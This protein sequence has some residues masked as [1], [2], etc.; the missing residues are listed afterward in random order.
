MDVSTMPIPIPG[1]AFFATALSLLCFLGLSAVA[2]AA[3]DADANASLSANDF[4]ALAG[5]KLEVVLKADKALN[6]SWISLGKDNQGR[7]LL[8]GQRHQALTR[9]TLGKDGKIVKTQVLMLPVSEIMGQLY[10]NDS[11]YIDGWGKAADGTELFGLFRLRDPE[12][13][14][15]FGRV[16]LLREWKHGWREHGAHAIVLGPDK[17]HLFI[18]CGNFVELPNDLA[19]TSPHKNYAD[20]QPLPREEDGNGFG[21]GKKPPGGFIARLD[22]DGRNPELYAAGQRNTY[23]IAFNPD[24]ELFGFD[25]DMEYDW[26]T[27]WY[28]PIRVYHATSGEDGG[29]REGTAK[30]PDYYPDGLPPVVNIGI[31]CPTGV[32]FGAGAKFPARYQKALFVQDW[33][34]ARLM[35]VHLK[36]KGSTY[37]STGWENL[38]APKS[39]HGNGVKKPLNLTGMVVGDDGALY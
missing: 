6:G 37:E 25:S 8:G 29:F 18:V 10:V 20:D 36:P 24:G 7:L 4:D 38:I 26:G 21:A 35:A 2:T 30:W 3:D 39:L 14:G 5:F 31:G 11:L 12:G 15:S 16:E 19:S 1:H 33:T 27:P 32:V 23:D 17:K 28:R 13:D 9:V 22:L 34:Y